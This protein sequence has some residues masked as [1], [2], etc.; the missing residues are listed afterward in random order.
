MVETGPGWSLTCADCLGSEGLSTLADKSVDHVITDPP[1]EAEAHTLQRRTKSTGWRNGKPAREKPL[2]F[3]AI[4]DGERRRSGTEIARVASRWVL[5][6]CQVEAAMLWR[7]ATAGGGA[8]YARTMVWTKPGAQPQLSGDRPGMGY[9]SI[10]VAHAS[11]GRTR[12]NA[13][14]KCGVYDAPRAAIEAGRQQLHMTEKPLSLMEAL[15]SDFTDPGELVCDPFAGSG[16]TGVACIQLGRRF[17]GWERDPKYFAVAV[18]RLR[19]AREQ[20]GLFERPAVEKFKQ[21][22]LSGVK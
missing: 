8:K 3:A 15:V 21:S 10:L 7:I 5:V 4:T 12:W 14:G 16:T 1:Y 9:E 11:P 2:D 13:G 19:A 18:K 6:F 17:V 20:L 22:T